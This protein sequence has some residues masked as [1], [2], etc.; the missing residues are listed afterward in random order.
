MVTRAYISW[1]HM[2]QRCLNPKNHKWEAYGGRGITICKRW[3]KFENFFADMGERPDGLSLDRID[4]NKGYSKDNCRWATHDVQA[5]NKRV[6]KDAVIFEGKSLKQ[7]VSITGI[8]YAT[9]HKRLET[10][11]TIHL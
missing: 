1:H 5:N 7:W 6:R 8:K 3:H 10:R 4:N 9:L 2:K 11:G